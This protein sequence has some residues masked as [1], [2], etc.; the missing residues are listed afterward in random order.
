MNQQIKTS[1]GV[2]IIII[3]A[4]TVGFFTWK[5]MTIKEDLTNPVGNKPTKACTQEA[6][7]CSD[8]SSVE[9]TGPNCEFA[10]CPEE[11]NSEKI[12]SV[13]E[14]ADNSDILAGTSVTVSGTV[15]S[16]VNPALAMDGNSATPKISCD[17]KG[18]TKT[19][20]L[21]DFNAG[22]HIGKKITV[23]GNV[24]YCHEN[25]QNHICSLENVKVNNLSKAEECNDKLGNL[26]GQGDY[27][28]NPAA[29]FCACM[30]GSLSVKETAAGQ[31][32]MCTI[33]SETIDEWEYFRKM[34]P[35]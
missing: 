11:K 28:P 27:M 4:V 14:L 10:K 6:K 29:F 12:Y 2:G 33:G 19:I 1:L 17:F 32:G 24:G 31:Q 25:K 8:G 15:G 34:N 5:A 16:C 3:I 13:D 30:G 20:T 35:V 21:K 18:E 9:R 22:Q 23:T 7:V 26:K